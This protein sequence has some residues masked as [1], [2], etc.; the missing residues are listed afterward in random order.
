MVCINLMS[1]LER[2]LLFC[3]EEGQFPQMLFCDLD[4]YPLIGR[5]FPGNPWSQL[6]RIAVGFELFQFGNI[7]H[8]PRIAIVKGFALTG[9]IIG[10]PATI[11]SILR[12]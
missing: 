8:G 9:N 11:D 4:C 2:C 12:F 3:C 10:F 7:P 5:Y 6:N 1:Q